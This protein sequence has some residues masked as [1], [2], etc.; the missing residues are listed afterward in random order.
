MHFLKRFD[1]EINIMIIFAEN[2]EYERHPPSKT[3][4]STFNSIIVYRNVSLK[5]NI[6]T[7]SHRNQSFF[8][9]MYPFTD[10]AYDRMVNQWHLFNMR[11]PILVIISTLYL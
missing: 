11:E 1:F 7:W 9:K 5:T 10:H 6:T 2:S 8:F 3:H 4:V